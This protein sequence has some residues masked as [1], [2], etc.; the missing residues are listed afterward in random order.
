[1]DDNDRASGEDRC[2]PRPHDASARIG[3]AP[4]RRRGHCDRLAERY[5]QAFG[6]PFADDDGQDQSRPMAV[7]G[8]HRG[9]LDRAGDRV[10][11][12]FRDRNIAQR[13]PAE[14]HRGHGPRGY[15]RPAARIHDDVCT[16]LTDDPRVDA[17]RIEV[18]V[19]GTEVTLSGSVASRTARRRAEAI[20]EAV[21]GVNHVQNDTRIDR[22]DRTL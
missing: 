13:K 19:S 5:H 4:P 9:L 2:R 21:S 8:T 11:S 20:A 17:R 6:P 1:M 10:A 18:T 22:C 3:G 16:R 14:T 7:G 12:W 15:T